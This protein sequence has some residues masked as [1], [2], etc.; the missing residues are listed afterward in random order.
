MI[1]VAVIVA[2]I[3]LVS[4]YEWRISRLRRALDRAEQGWGDAMADVD[5]LC[6]NGNSAQAVD[7]VRCVRREIV[8]PS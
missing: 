4:R 5:F 7:V 6:E 8:R 1:G 3:L 2:A